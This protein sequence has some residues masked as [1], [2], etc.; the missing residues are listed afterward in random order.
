VL[1]EGWSHAGLVLETGA[2]HWRKE[3][4]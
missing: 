3:T 4:R 2:I 1:T